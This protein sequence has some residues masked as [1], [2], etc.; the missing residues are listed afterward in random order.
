M[1]KNLT[2][3]QVRLLEIFRWFHDFCVEHNLHYY[4]LGGT[5]LGAA[6]HQGFI[7]WDDDVDVGMPTQDYLRLIQLIQQNTSDYYVIESPINAAEGFWYPFTKLYD[8]STTLVENTAEHIKRGIYIDIFPLEGMGNTA[9]ETQRN[10]RK[11]ERKLNLLL[12]R[13]TGIRAG[14]KWYKNVFV[15]IARLL[16]NWLVN[17]K[18]LYAQIHQ[19]STQTDFDSK[20]YGGNPCGAWR[21]KEIMARDIYGKPTLYQFEN[22]QVFGVEKPNEYLTHMYGNWRQ[23]PPKEKQKTHHDFI[24]FDLNKSYLCGDNPI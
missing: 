15:Y 10:Y 4:T 23:L 18:K 12:A 7:P 2:P 19:L 5:M 3:L 21:L 16:P 1:A 22:I 6:R 24:S 8:T 13:T 17:N 9:E 11:L 20:A 14:R